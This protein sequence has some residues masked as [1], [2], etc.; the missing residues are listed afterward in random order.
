[1]SRFFLMCDRASEMGGVQR[2]V[3]TLSDALIDLGRDVEIISVSEA[4]PPRI[5]A[6]K[7]V[8]AERVLYRSRFWWRILRRIRLGPIHFS[9]MRVERLSFIQRR[10]AVRTL[11]RISEENPG[12]AFIAMNGFS[13][14]LL[15]EAKL[16]RS[17]SL[18][19]YH[20]SY[21][22]LHN[23]RA[24]ASL[25]KVSR[26][27]DM[28]VALTE[29]D[30]A[31]FRQ[32]GFERV[33][34]I[35]NPVPFYPDSVP[36]ISERGDVVVSIGRF[37]PQKSFDM[38]VRAWR[39]VKE[40]APSW[41]LEI[42]GDGDDSSIASLK[43]LVDALELSDRVS[44]MGPISDVSSRLRSAGIYALSSRY[45]GLP[46][47][48]LEAMACGLPCVATDCSPGVRALM[49]AAGSPVAPVGQPEELGRRILAL[50]RNEDRRSSIAARGRAYAEG[51]RP[52]ATAR[53]W[54][55]HVER[56]QGEKGAAL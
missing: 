56:I 37:T 46:M 45:E 25:R 21:A 30:A 27:V 18:V 6:Q 49:E 40:E 50:V 36:A 4:L 48:L 55:D 8:V 12:S 35:S 44:I 51:F 13:A 54:I 10:Q 53:N 32:A 14:E 34:W 28:F 7:H 22:H 26:N 24:H 16:N 5:L 29:D 41:S 2:V 20:N 52:D 19:Q 15:A 43:H 11:R 47:V 42:Y 31:L 33:E 3:R 9:S 23:D 17:L 39:T 38:L 1:M